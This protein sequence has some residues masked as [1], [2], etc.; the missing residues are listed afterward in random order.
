MKTK[1]S[2]VKK[3]S[4]TRLR[5]VA[6]WYLD[7]FGGTRARVR[8]ALKRRIRQAEEVHGPSPE[9]KSW[10]DSITDELERLG[11]INDAEFAA[12]RVQRGLRMHK[13]RRAIAHDLKQ[14]GVEKHVADS[15]IREVFT[16]DSELD[17]RSAAAYVERKRIG[18]L[19]EN[20]SQY[21]DKDLAR[22][23]RRGF[24]YDISRRALVGDLKIERAKTPRG[25]MHKLT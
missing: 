5:N 11:L 22:M 3:I 6:L 2:K 9:A 10:M 14:A 17:L 15:A 18:H 20:P 24:S 1:D 4:Q 12:S 21:Y 7:R 13:S 23:A 16:N 25:S 19:R 8:H